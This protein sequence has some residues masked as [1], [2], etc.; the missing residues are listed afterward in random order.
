MAALM[1]IGSGVFVMPQTTQAAVKDWQKSASM[2]TYDKNGFTSA[3]F[4]ESLKDWKATGANYISLVIPYY[5]NNKTSSEILAKPYTPSDEVLSEAIQYAHSIG[6]KVMLKVHITS[7]DSAWQ[8]YINPTN[9]DA[10]FASYGMMLNH[11]ADIAEKNQAEEICIGTELITMS[12]NPENTQNW[13]TMIDAIR[14]HYHGLL[15][16]SAN[17]GGTSFMEEASHIGFW[18]HLDYIGLSAY[19]SLAPETWNPKMQDFLKS[20]KYWDQTIVQPLSKKFNKPILFTEIGYRSL[21]GANTDPYNGDRMADV[22]LDLQA[23]LYQALFQYWNTK[24]YMAGI[25]MWDWKVDSLEGGP[26]NNQYTVH[27]KP[28]EEVLKQWFTNSKPANKIITASVRAKTNPNSILGEWTELNVA[29]TTT[30]KRG[31]Q[32]LQA[33][34]LNRPNYTYIT[35]WQV[36]GGDPIWM[37]DENTDHI[38]EQ[39]QI[40]TT[41]WWWKGAGPYKITFIS[42]EFAEKGGRI[43]G[44]RTID[45]YL[46]P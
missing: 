26:G 40:D 36:D 29:T 25:H 15:T 22:D 1:I 43:L 8:A 39:S 41:N 9:K 10:W 32:I 12:T 44:Q 18:D 4:K 21:Q 19:F 14:A 42:R 34:L 2:Y 33:H 11:L 28:A 13:I 5:Q 6:L 16:Y 24:P 31:S 46:K 45:V 7:D 3:E 27:H 38:Y 35:S 20:W 23:N 30:L 37:T 17:W